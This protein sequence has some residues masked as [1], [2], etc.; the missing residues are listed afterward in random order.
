MYEVVN[1]SLY[2]ISKETPR[3]ANLTRE[4]VVVDRTDVF[5]VRHT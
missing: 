4:R 1:E 2:F 3:V 5:Q